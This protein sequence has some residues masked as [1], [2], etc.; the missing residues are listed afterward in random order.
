VWCVVVGVGVRLLLLINFFFV[1]VCLVGACTRLEPMAA[2]GYYLVKDE[3][4]VKKVV[5]EPYMEMWK[6]VI[7]TDLA[8][9]PLCQ[10]RL[11]VPAGADGYMRPKLHCDV[12]RHVVATLLDNGAVDRNPCNCENRGFGRVLDEVGV[13]GGCVDVCSRW[14]NLSECCKMAKGA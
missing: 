1:C 10:G 9:M 6:S 14:K 11:N 4:G 3:S 2:K 5:A 13:G 8:E 12:C 7:N